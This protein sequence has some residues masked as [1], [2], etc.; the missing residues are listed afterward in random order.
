M[1]GSCCAPG[2]QP[3]NKQPQNSP[4]SS[5]CCC[6]GPQNCSCSPLPFDSDQRAA[7]AWVLRSR[8]SIPLGQYR[9]RQ[10]SGYGELWTASP[11]EKEH[12]LRATLRHPRP[13]PRL[14]S[15]L[16][17]AVSPSELS[18]WRAVARHPALKAA[19]R[20]AA[21]QK[22]L[23]V[24]SPLHQEGWLLRSYARQHR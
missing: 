9:V 17:A 13:L 18:S 7:Q 8:A 16:L 14:T 22:Q 4:A 2:Q 21:V 24:V 11:N 5:S 10:S 23:F 15:A 6:S 19:Q 3:A 20:P 12:G 1:W